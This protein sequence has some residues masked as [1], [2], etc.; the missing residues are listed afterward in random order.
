MV[1]AEKPFDIYWSFSS[2]PANKYVTLSA[3]NIVT[4]DGKTA[5]KL[6][7]IVNGTV[8]EYTDAD[9]PITEDGFF[10]LGGNWSS[11]T[12]R[13][14]EKAPAL[15]DGYMDMDSALD[16]FKNWISQTSNYSNIEFKNGAVTPYSAMIKSSSEF[17]SDS[18]ARLYLDSHGKTSNLMIGLRTSGGLNHYETSEMN[19]YYF[20]II[21]DSR[22]MLCK[23]V[24]GNVQT[25]VETAQGTDLLKATE[26]GAY[27]DVSALNEENV[28][29]I[30][31]KING[32]EVINYIDDKKPITEKG[33]LAFIDYSG[34][35]ITIDSGE[36]QS[37]VITSPSEYEVIQRDDDDKATV[38]V[39]GS[40]KTAE[41]QKTFVVIKND[42]ETVVN[43]E[44]Q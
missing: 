40:V 19:G 43:D 32:T 39:T 7:F 37:V 29:R 44:I 41:N 30:V 33:S 42:S 13:E 26:N 15:D 17:D 38:R 12:V 6:K 3:E 35:K 2:I 28:V 10:C 25:F 1:L 27:F 23:A 20:Q 24:N 21:S 9:N 4:E 11:Y 18:G 8:L 5:V 31:L 22:I 14:I 16:S 36:D 34:N